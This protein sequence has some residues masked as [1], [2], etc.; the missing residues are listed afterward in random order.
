VL[1]KLGAKNV[2]ANLPET[3]RLVGFG[4]F[5][6]ERIVEQNPDV[7]IAIS[8]GRPNITTQALSAS[9]VWG[10]L[11][12]VQSGRVHEVSD[13]V[14]LQAAGPRVSLILDELSRILYPNVF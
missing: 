7:I 11:K 5:S 14:Y 1:S 2:A 6:V 4:D 3:F 9:P 8:P 13:V 12:A 10:S